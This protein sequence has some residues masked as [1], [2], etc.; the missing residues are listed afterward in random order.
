MKFKIKNKYFLNLMLKILVIICWGR[1]GLG[2]GLIFLL[3]NY[4]FNKYF[5]NEN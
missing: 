5:G 4:D 3:E 1:K 2:K